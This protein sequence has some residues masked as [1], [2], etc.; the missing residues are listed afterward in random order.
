MMNRAHFEKSTNLHQQIEHAGYILPAI[1]DFL[2]MK[3]KYFIFFLLPIL[4]PACE[5]TEKIDDF[6]LRPSKLVVNCFFNSDSIWEF[7]VSK[8]LSVLDNAELK[9]IRNANVKIFREGTLLDSILVADGDGRYRTS[10]NLPQVGKEFSIEISS[11]SFKEKLYARDIVPEKVEISDAKIIITDS[12][13][14]DYGYYSYGY[15]N[16]SFEISFDDPADADNYYEIKVFY[17]DSIFSFPETGPVFSYLA[18]R[19]IGISSED[20][21]VVNPS[22]YATSSLLISDYY[23]DGQ[24]KSLSL[25][26]N[27][28]SAQKKKGYYLE[29]ISLSREGYLYQK[30]IA[31]YDNSR[32]DP[33]SEPV[34]IYSNIE[35]GFGIFSAYSRSI[36]SLETRF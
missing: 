7:Q 31:D 36:Y 9:L 24:R 16:G 8:S 15:M 28:W 17:L 2:R 20:L 4:F 21:S 11:P 3:A 27:D 5:T 25:D 18:K 12:A 34:M 22:D 29:L 14:Y 35:N 33:F 10:N 6:P 23:F 13:F 1:S 26:F 32:G 19:M 30:T